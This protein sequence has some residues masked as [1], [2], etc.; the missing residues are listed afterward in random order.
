MVNKKIWLGILVMMLVFG[1]VVV[2][3]DNYSTSGGGGGGGNTD[4][5]GTWANTTAGY[6]IKFTKTTYELDKGYY[7]TDPFNAEEEGTYTVKGNTV[8][9]S[10]TKGPRTGTISGNKITFTGWSVTKQ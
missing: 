5:S 6:C 10:S 4:L 9:M 2:G 7:G 3:C 1:M 8:N